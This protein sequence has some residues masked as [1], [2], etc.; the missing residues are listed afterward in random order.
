[1]ERRI[2]GEEDVHMIVFLSVWEHSPT[3]EQGQ[4]DKTV[5]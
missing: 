1:M 4:E 5:I 3:S 2:E